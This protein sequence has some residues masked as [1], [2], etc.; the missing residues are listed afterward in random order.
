MLETYIRYFLGTILFAF[1]F[2]IIIVIT[3]IL[4]TWFKESVERFWKDRYGLK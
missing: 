2:I 3:I 1:T 4:W